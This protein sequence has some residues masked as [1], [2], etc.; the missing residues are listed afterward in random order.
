[1]SRLSLDLVGLPYP[2]GM[3]SGHIPGSYNL[4]E[5]SVVDPETACI[6]DQEQIKKSKKQKKMNELNP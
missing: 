3:K 2:V 4:P 5:D 6:S 1:M